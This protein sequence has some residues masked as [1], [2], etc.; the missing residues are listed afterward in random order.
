MG[1]R[2]FEYRKITIDMKGE[3]LLKSEGF[4]QEFEVFSK[5]SDTSPLQYQFSMLAPNSELALIMAQE[6]FM[7]REPVADI[8]VVKRSDIRKMSLEEKQSL[9]RLDNKDYRNTKGYGYLKK[10]WRQYE[11]GMLDEKEI[12]SWGEEKKSENG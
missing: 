5:R 3:N 4:Y 8:W 1:A 2:G 10:K 9:Q 7:R 11:Q 12:L 6:N